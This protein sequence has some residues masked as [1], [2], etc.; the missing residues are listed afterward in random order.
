MEEQLIL[1]TISAVITTCT[2]STVC[3]PI[4]TCAV[5]AI[6]TVSAACTVA[7][8]NVAVTVGSTVVANG[9]ARGVGG[10][11]ETERRQK[12]RDRPEVCLT[13]DPA[14]SLMEFGTC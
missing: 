4:T 3:T 8:V 14:S 9:R 7:T 6:D 12:S 2:I 13:Y 1:C 5:P 10:S 11:A